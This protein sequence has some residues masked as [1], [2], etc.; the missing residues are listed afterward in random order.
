MRAMVKPRTRLEVGVSV[1]TRASQLSTMTRVGVRTRARIN[2]SRIVKLLLRARHNG[3][4]VFSRRLARPR[5][6][7]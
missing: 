2:V 5:E 6:R 3:A 7:R 1:T 4:Q